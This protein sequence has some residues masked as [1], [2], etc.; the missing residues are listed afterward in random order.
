ML[1]KKEQE[2]F[3]ELFLDYQGALGFQCY[4]HGRSEAE[5]HYNEKLA[6]DHRA[7]RDACMEEAKFL[8]QEILKLLGMDKKEA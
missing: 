2:R 7:E 3:A 5:A 1:S 6:N 4:W 8:E